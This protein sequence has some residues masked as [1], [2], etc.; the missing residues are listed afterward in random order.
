MNSQ[1]K[2]YLDN[3]KELNRKEQQLFIKIKQQNKQ[4]EDERNN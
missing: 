2:E 3:L 1:Y 4:K